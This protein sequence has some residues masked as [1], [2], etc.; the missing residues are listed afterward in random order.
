MQE[1]GRE[2]GKLTCK[3]EVRERGRPAE[4]HAREV[5]REREDSRKRCMQGVLLGLNRRER[6]GERCMHA[7]K[8]RVTGI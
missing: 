3:Q 5:R 8:V 1:C 6:G 7:C 2:R 4:M